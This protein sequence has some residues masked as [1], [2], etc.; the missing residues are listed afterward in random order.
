M[1]KH[2]PY[3]GSSATRDIACPG[4]KKQ[5]ENI[6]PRPAGQAAIDGSMHHEV[7]E[8]CFRDEVTPS[9]CLGLIYK[10]EGTEITREF[11]EDDLDLS[12]AAYTRTNELLDA[13]DIDYYFIEPFV[14]YIHG[15]S[16]GSIDLIGLSRNKTTLL[17]IDYK[18]GSHPVD[19]EYNEQC[20]VYGLSAREDKL[21][22]DMFEDVERIV[23]AIVQPRVKGGVS[24]WI[25]DITWLD[26]FEWRYTAAMKSDALLA[27]EHCRY[28][29][30]EA[31]CAVKRQSVSDALLLT[32]AH[33]NELVSA[34]AMVTEVEAWLK[35]M[36]EEMYWQMTR[37]VSVTGWKVVEKRATRRW[38]D[39]AALEAALKNSKLAK[40]TTHETKCLSPAQMEKA[41]K[42]A[43]V[44]LDLSEFIISVSSGTTIAPD[45]DG[46]EAVVVSDVTGTL[47][48]VME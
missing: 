39:L 41:I 29:P 10:E 7:M 6:K 26:A 22:A 40:K 23:F 13:F 45:D 43:G 5:S 21:T 27:G 17:I 18:F 11:T 4:N 8:Q 47:K 37:G 35:S 14:Q 15:V 19:A 28:C 1:A 24:K 44:T 20:G 38:D 25:T 42:K 2:L 16:G 36:K 48:D 3:G 9:D 34:A 33:H 31:F 30:A 46:R 12:Y 32:G